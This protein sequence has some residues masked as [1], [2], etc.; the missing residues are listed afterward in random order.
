MT[1]V[2]VRGYVVAFLAAFGC[3]G[4]S[5][6]ARAV[7]TLP[8]QIYPSFAPSSIK[9]GDTST[10][11]LSILDPNDFGVSSVAFTDNLPSGM[12]VASPSGLSSDCGG[13]AT[14]NPGSSTVSLG[15]GGPTTGCVV[16]VNVVG[17]EPGALVD[18][19]DVTSSAGTGDTHSATLTV[20]AAPDVFA[21]FGDPV[22]GFPSWVAPGVTVPLQV[23]VDNEDPST[24][25]TGVGFTNTLSS[26]LAIANPSGLTVQGGCTPGEVTLPSSNTLALSGATLAPAPDLLNPPLDSICL[27][28]VDVVATA[29]GLQTSSTG[30]V[31]FNE[32]LSVA[33]ATAKLPVV[34]SGPRIY[35]GN[36][37]P[38][39][40][41]IE[42]ARTDGSVGASLGRSGQ[43]NLAHSGVG[44]AIDAKAG[45]IYWADVGGAISW[46]S[47]DDGSNGVLAAAGADLG[48][49]QGVAIDPG[50][51]RI[52]WTN[53][54]DDT[55]S[56]ASLA[57]SGGGDLYTSAHTGGATIDKP[58]AVAI[59]P[60]NGR[61][62]WTNGAG[63]HPISYANL[64]GSGGGGDLNTTGAS[65]DT[66]TGLAIDT[67]NGLVYWANEG[68]NRISYAHLDESGGANLTTP[69]AT[70]D[71]P[72]GIAI[73]P[74][75]NKIWW[76]NEADDSISY[77][78]LGSSGG[79]LSTPGTTPTGPGFPSLLYPPQS[80]TAPVITGGTTAGSTLHCSTGTWAPD[81][82]GEFFYR[83]PQSFSYLWQ[84]NGTSIT[85]ATSSSY[86]APT[87]GS[88]TCNVTAVNAA[89]TDSATSA[90]TTVTL[91]P[92][93]STG[94]PT[95]SGTAMQAH[96]LTES[97]GSW[98]NSPTG[99]VYRWL[100]CDT[101]GNNCSPI[102][103]AAAQTYTLTATDVG[104]TIRVQESAS[105]AGGS[106]AATSAPTV[107]VSRLPS[108]PVLSGLTLKPKTF[109]AAP[110]ATASAKRYG[111]TVAYRDTEAAKATFT[112]WRREPGIRRHGKCVAQH[113]NQTGNSCTRLVHVGG[114]SHTDTAGS[115]RLHFS[116]RVKGH[117]LAPGRYVL[118]EVAHSNGL[119]SKPTKT[120]FRVKKRA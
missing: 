36:L 25:L 63:T 55:I 100:D 49:P 117:A 12:V 23:N 119:A 78:T 10:L 113:G 74:T 8:A 16:S 1:R 5:G 88:Y 91:P 62:Y 111:S 106:T 67:A 46:A 75:Q 58:D 96:T 92:P 20:V 86:A 18:S 101:G 42:F 56:W 120:S 26:G 82:L 24:A 22:F 34:G 68:D 76:A 80:T 83:A 73:D 69:G 102:A 70:V 104:H 103:G 48:S 19:V 30:P 89:G 7:T 43:V 107:V 60:A 33:A 9:V 52:Y 29:N 116:G 71:Q 14:A 31:T 17:A 98:T 114:F 87:A 99:F 4:T 6:A 85:G 95:I 35:W 77:L 112:L 13:T 50:L 84:R 81:Q 66:P 90:V 64:D 79:T 61:I 94:L 21:V 93:V 115:N 27:V 109:L 39:P 51:G 45:R 97:H 47:L 28:T 54:T 40:S 11:N 108:A 110:S 37:R 57:G 15:A 44:T 65:V 41:T 53:F 118:R 59:D 2:W 32:G 105:N 72:G 3:L 38:G